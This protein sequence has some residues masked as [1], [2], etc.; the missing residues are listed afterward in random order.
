LLFWFHVQLLVQN[1]AAGILDG[2][3][4]GIK[5]K[6]EEHA[7][8]KGIFSAQTPSELLESI[9]MKGSSVEP[10]QSN[11]DD[12]IEELSIGSRPLPPYIS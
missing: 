9:F 5:G 12:L 11:P 3:I 1:P 2:I 10:S 8:M 7:E 4:K 6:A